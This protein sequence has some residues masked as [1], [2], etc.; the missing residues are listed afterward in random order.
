MVNS[1]KQH[2]EKLNEAFEELI[3]E[4]INIQNVA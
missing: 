1:W 2:G 4:K 3:H